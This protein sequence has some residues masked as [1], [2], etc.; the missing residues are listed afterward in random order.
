MRQEMPAAV[1]NSFC[2]HSHYMFPVFLCLV[3]EKLYL[4]YACVVYENIYVTETLY[5]IV[6]RFFYFFI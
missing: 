3:Y 2:V 5:D 6:S 1:E 4:S